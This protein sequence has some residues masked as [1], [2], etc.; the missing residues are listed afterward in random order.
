MLVLS[1]FLHHLQNNPRKHNASVTFEVSPP[2]ENIQFLKEKILRYVESGDYY[3]DIAKVYRK[4]EHYLQRDIS[5]GKFSK[6]AVIM[7]VD[8]TALSNWPL[9]KKAGFSHLG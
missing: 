1:L 6:P 7:D 2:M 9:I 4:A 3:R 8:E 5:S